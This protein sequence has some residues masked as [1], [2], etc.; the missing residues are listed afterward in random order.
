MITGLTSMTV[1]MYIAECAPMFIRGR[2]VSVNVAMIAGGQFIANVVDGIFSFDITGW[3]W[4]KA[5]SVVL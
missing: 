2:L 4:V 1:P 5:V 3:R